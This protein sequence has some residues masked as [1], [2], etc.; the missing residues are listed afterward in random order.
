MKGYY[1]KMERRLRITI[2]A[3]I[4][5]DNKVLFVHTPGGS[6]ELPGGKM[7]FGETPQA[8]LCREL[9][10]ELGITRVEIGRPISVFNI[11]TK[12]H[13]IARYHFCVVVFECR[14]SKS[15]FYLS[16]E[17]DKWRW[18]TAAGVRMLKME[19]GYKRTV[20]KHLRS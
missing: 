5:R 17:H 20:I 15:R 19:S 3:L 14:I 18:V 9:K 7:E 6:W 4:L 11:M 8:V 13:D 2:K 12:F 16:E 1:P 10:E